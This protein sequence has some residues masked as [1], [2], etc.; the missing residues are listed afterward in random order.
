M[1]K[2]RALQNWSQDYQSCKAGATLPSKRGTGNPAS[3]QDGA[4]SVLLDPKEIK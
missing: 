2:L 3:T 4:C 1:S